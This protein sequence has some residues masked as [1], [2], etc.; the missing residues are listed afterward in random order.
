MCKHLCDHSVLNLPKQIDLT[1][2][3]TLAIA[4]SG[5][6]FSLLGLFCLFFGCLES[7]FLLSLL[8]RYFFFRSFLRFFFSLRLSF[9]LILLLLG[10]FCDSSL[11]LGR[12]FYPGSLSLCISFGDAS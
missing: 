12:F 4:T 9:F 2:D 5:F 7:S 10:S 1:V 6:L 8:F 11:L 3:P